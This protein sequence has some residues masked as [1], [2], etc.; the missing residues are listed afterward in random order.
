MLY[1]TSIVLGN[2]FVHW[3]GIIKYAGLVFPAGVVFVGL[4]FSFRD[5]VQ[6]NWGDAG[7]WVWMLVATVITLFL[8]W[9]IAIAS[10]SAFLVSEA[11][12]WLAFR[13]FKYPFH[14]RIWLSNLLSTPL[15]S[16]IFVTVAFGFNWPAI[17]GQAVVKYLSGLLVIPFILWKRRKN[18]EAQLTK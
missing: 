12:D 7:T 5:F 17:W 9:E 8:N 3:F 2:L 14:K 1:L 6:R 4:T 18:A 11:V 16:L 10:C 15:D 13:Y